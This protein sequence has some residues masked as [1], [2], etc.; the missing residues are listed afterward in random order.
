MGLGMI[1]VV[2]AAN[3]KPV[4]TDLKKR[5]EKFFRIGRIERSD[6]GKARVAFSGALNLG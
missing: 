3:V 5:R 1:L 2:P 4:E 6:A